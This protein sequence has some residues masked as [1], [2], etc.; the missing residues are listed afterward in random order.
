VRS[1]QA[2]LVNDNNIPVATPVG[3]TPDQEYFQID[4]ELEIDNPGI[5]SGNYFIMVKASDE[6][7]TTRTFQPV[8]IKGI[9]VELRRLLVIT[10]LNTL[11]SNVY[12]IDS[13]YNINRILGI[14]REYVGSAISSKYKQLYY[15]SPDP[16]QLNTYDLQ[17]TLMAW[18]YSA[19]LPYPVLEDVYYTENL[20][21]IASQNGDII[22][23]NSVG[24]NKFGTLTHND[25][26]P[27]KIF[28]HYDFIVA[29]QRTRSNQYR[30]FAIFFAETGA[31]AN[32]YRSDLEVISFFSR[33]E[34]E[35]IA[36]G[37]E[38]GQAKTIVYGIEENNGLEPATMPSGIVLDGV[39]IN[40][41]EVL[42]A[43]DFGVIEY[44]IQTFQYHQVFTHDD[45]TAMDYDTLNQYLAIARDDKIFFYNYPGANLLETVSMAEPVLNIHFLY[46]K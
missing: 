33:N 12:L 44:N 35:I 21:Y 8:E 20:V 22:G 43:M 46:N 13:A 40:E 2:S 14:S 18:D 27:E 28:K 19:L 1:V 3:A 29:D 39:Y 25:R 9:P 42:L 4:F 38:N 15:I 37:N 36:F 34:N 24:Q 31:F 10:R 5:V 17:D 26:V 30:Y 32:Q 11:K 23:L 45:V 6:V 41:N 7:S 16:S